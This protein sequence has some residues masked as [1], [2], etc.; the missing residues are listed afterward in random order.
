MRAAG[1]RC[2]RDVVQQVVQQI[3]RRIFAIARFAEFVQ[4]LDL[5]I[6]LAQQALQRRAAFQAVGAHRFED[7]ADDPPQLEHRLRRRHLFELFGD[8]GQNLQILH[9]AF[10]ADVAQQ[11]DL[12]SRPQAAA[13]IAPPKSIAR[14][15]PGDCGCGLL[16]GLQIEQQQRAFGQQRAAAHGAQIVEQRQQHQR[17][18][19]AAR[20]NAL[21]IRRQLHH[22]A[23]QCIQAVDLTLLIVAGLEQVARDVLHLLGEQ[24]RTV[25]LDQAQHAMGR[26]QLIAR[27]FSSNTR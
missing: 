4:A 15:A 26:M 25:N 23:H 1:G 27:I 7:R 10:A 5:P 12:E 9:R 19:P 2:A 11:A 20:Q 17:Q 18:I 6:R 8:L 13:P 3:D 14:P 24:R 16:I 21:E 22:G